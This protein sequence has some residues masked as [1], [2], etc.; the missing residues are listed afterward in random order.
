[1]FRVSKSAENQKDDQ[2]VAATVSGSLNRIAGKIK[3]A[4]N[5]REI[6]KINRS[7]VGCPWGKRHYP[8]FILTKD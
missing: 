8:A 7:D 2:L 1:M 3:R 6:R 4:A 5:G